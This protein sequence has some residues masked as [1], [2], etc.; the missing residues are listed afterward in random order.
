MGDIRVICARDLQV[1]MTILNGKRTVLVESIENDASC[2]GIHVNTVRRPLYIKG[3]KGKYIPNP[4]GRRIV[5][6]DGCYDRAAVITVQMP[7]SE[8]VPTQ[9]TA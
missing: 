1:G 3:A 4:E 6:S 5:Y 9:R 7:V 2:L 8:N